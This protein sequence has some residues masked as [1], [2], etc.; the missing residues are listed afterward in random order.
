MSGL[1]KCPGWGEAADAIAADGFAV[2]LFAPIA[3]EV[4]RMPMRMGRSIAVLAACV[5]WAPAAWAQQPSPDQISAIRASCRSD[6]M[7]NCSGV[8]RGGAEALACLRQHMAQLSSGCQAAVSAVA[9]K[10]AAP[11]AAAVPATPPAPPPAAVAA[12]PAAA[13]V[14][15]TAPAAP[16]PST[17]SA[18]EPKADSAP[19]PQKPRAAPPAPAPAR[20]AVTTPVAPPA[21]QAAPPTSLGPIPPL[22]PRARLMILRACGSE[23]QAYCSNVPA[24]GG[25]IVDCLAANG[26]SLSPGCRQAIL[27]AR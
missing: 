10:G 6:F 21:P 13:P 12:P 24:G 8:P 5:V 11:A 25:R 15:S 20:T 22:P 16:R 19:P 17:A 7:A 2:N 3:D 23:H 18:P 14:V 9:P 4:P 26:A 27:S 1:R